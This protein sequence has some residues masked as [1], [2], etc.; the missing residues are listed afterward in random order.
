MIW[1]WPHFQWPRDMCI[2]VNININIFNIFQ[3][4]D[5]HIIWILY[6]YNDIPS[7]WHWPQTLKR[8][9]PQITRVLRNMWPSKHTLSREVARCLALET[10]STGSPERVRYGKWPS[11][12]KKIKGQGAR[13]DGIY[14]VKSCHHWEFSFMS[15]TPIKTA[16]SLNQSHTWK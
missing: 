11:T 1:R 16:Q 13:W 15:L 7:H 2:C 8:Y 3:Y 12:W 14:Q 9:G 6:G 4:Y 5:N 10:Y